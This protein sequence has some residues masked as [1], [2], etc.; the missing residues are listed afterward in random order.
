[1]GGSKF[2]LPDLPDLFSA[3]K[4]FGKTA[5]HDLGLLTSSVKSVV[6]KL[7]N[8]QG[9]NLGF[10]GRTENREDTEAEDTEAEQD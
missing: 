10:W 5:A 8:M 2:T 3:A 4:M 9:P 6:D 1:M 7:E